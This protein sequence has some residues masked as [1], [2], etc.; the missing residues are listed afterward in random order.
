MKLFSN[1][2]HLWKHLWKKCFAL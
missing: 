1:V 2:K